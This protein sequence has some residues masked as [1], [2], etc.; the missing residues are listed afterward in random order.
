[1]IH[2][3]IATRTMAAA[4]GLALAVPTIATA[5][6]PAPLTPE[7]IAQIRELLNAQDQAEVNTP[8]EIEQLRRVLRDA[9]AATDAPG[10]SNQSRVVLRS[11]R[12]EVGA[13]GRGEPFQVQ[14][15]TL[16]EGYVTSLAFYDN[17]GVAWP[18]ESVAYDREAFAVNNDGCETSTNEELGALGNV[19]V[20]SPC[21]F[22]TSAN[23]Q[24]LLRGETRPIPF[25]VRSGSRDDTI[26][27]DG[28][29]TIAVQSDA[30]RPLGRDRQ[31]NIDNDWTAP[32]SRAIRID[33]I[34]AVNGGV[35]PIVIAP[36]ITTDLSF[37][38]ASRTP[39]PV[40]EVSYA[41][42]VIAV[43]GSCEPEEAGL[44]TLQLSDE[45]STIYVTACQGARATLA[46]RLQGRAGA[47]SLLAV[48]ARQGMRQPDGTLS[49]TVPGVSP[50]TPQ[51][52]AAGAGVAGRPGTVRAGGFTHDRFLD[53]FLFGTPPQG[54][55]RASVSG[56]GDFPAEA[57]IFDGGLY[58]R[59]AF[60]VVNPAYDASSQTSDGTVFV[61][62]YA[63]PVS[64]ILASDLSGRELVLN[65]TY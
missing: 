16:A 39:W 2:M 49:I 18:V 55:R 31:G 11:G 8:A 50:I 24:V 1:M 33:P 12:I 51:V 63:P 14:P 27:A 25:D 34:E 30:P 48:P 20:L 43:N 44:T 13:F 28:L 59:G 26:S 60:R 41:P 52:T 56:A 62:K 47:I 57:W 5:Q 46:V 19:L 7:Q 64:R 29:V 61:W 38:D 22:W 4:L 53:E 45:A 42:G 15:V 32:A 9:E 21:S 23:M 58:I 54:A 65:V 36:G 6:D 17:G 37:M 10:Y 40:A 35:N 3:S